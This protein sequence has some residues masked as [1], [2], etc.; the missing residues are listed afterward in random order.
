M[1]IDWSSFGIEQSSSVTNDTISQ[2]QKLLG[3]IFPSSYLDLFTYSDKSSPE[4]S[5]FPYDENESCI[6]EFFELSPDIRPYTIAWYARAGGT[7]GLPTGIVP[8]ARDAGDY[9]VCFNF[10]KPSIT[11][12]VFDPNS[13][14]L[15]FVT[16]S[17]EEFVG[18]WTE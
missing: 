5:S 11:V 18:L 4:I 3:V 1:K 14:S 2:T 7:A 9:L 16:N 6:S 12:E 15:Y 13:S 10:N 17:F 8:I